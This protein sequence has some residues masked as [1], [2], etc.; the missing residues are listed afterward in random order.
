MYAHSR[1]PLCKDI[2]R[3]EEKCPE[4]WVGTKGTWWR[5]FSKFRIPKDAQA[6]TM[7]PQLW[8]LA[9]IL[10][11]KKLDKATRICLGFIWYIIWTHPLVWNTLYGIVV[12]Y[13]G[14]GI[15]KKFGYPANVDDENSEICWELI[16]NHHKGQPPSPLSLFPL[17]KFWSGVPYI[18]NS[19]RAEGKARSFTRGSALK[20]SR[21]R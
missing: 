12:E 17:W 13:K 9:I 1:S 10:Q 19:N 11:K 8:K 5:L 3:H 21:G 16:V 2:Q 15:G 20:A 4:L 6:T 7:W 14:I 18:I